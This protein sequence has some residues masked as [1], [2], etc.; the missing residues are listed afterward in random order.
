[1]RMAMKTGLLWY[2]DD[3]GRDLAEKVRR[4][5]AY[6]KQKYGREAMLC[7][8]NPA[9]LKEAMTV[10]GVEV[11]ALSTVLNNHFWLGIE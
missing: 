6:Y 11:K 3:K 4:A 5:V 10:D 1:M 9:M 7:Y 8:V 2:D